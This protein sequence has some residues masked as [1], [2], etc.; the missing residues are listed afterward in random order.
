VELHEY[1]V[2]SEQPVDVSAHVIPF[3]FF[4][5]SIF[6]GKQPVPNDSSIIETEQVEHTPGIMQFEADPLIKFE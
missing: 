3:E 6:V 2:V 1:I 4:E 5:M